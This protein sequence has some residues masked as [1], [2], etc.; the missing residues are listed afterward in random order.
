MVRVL[1]I[2]SFINTVMKKLIILMLLLSVFMGV[3]TNI[4]WFTLYGTEFSGPISLIK[5]NL[6]TAFEMVHW[7]ILLLAHAMV[8]SLIFLTKNKN[9]ML[10]LT[11]F[12]LQ[13]L[14]IYMSFDLLA[15]F[16]LIPFMVVWIIAVI[17]QRKLTKNP[18]I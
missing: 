9:F 6:F 18:I 11:W 10:L 12:P 15:S 3:S 4:G 1:V 8:V 7:S 2:K 13:F 14:I 17:K 5:G 16:F